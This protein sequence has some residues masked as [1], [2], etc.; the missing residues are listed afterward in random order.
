MDVTTPIPWRRYFARTF[1]YMVHV[2][3][4]LTIGLLII[5]VLCDY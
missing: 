3:L 2:A 1:D 4:F 5:Q